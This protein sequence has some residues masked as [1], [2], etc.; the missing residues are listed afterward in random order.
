M[1]RKKQETLVLFPEVMRFT[2]KF[3]DAQ[4]GSLIRSVFSYR[5]EGEVYSGEDM[6]VDV[7]FQTIAGQ[8]DRLLEH[9]EINAKNAS[10]SEKVRENLPAGEKEQPEAESGETEQGEAESSEMQRNHPPILSNPIRS[11]PIQVEEEAAKPPTHQR[12]SPPSVEE[13]RAYCLEKGYSLAPERFVD[14]YA[15]IGW[16]VGKNPMKDWKAALRNWAQKEVPQTAPPEDG[17]C[18]YVLA[19]AEDPWEVAMRERRARDA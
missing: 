2:Q 12:F 16:R 14:Y 19:P 3:S 17:H 7:A 15:S 13:V 11:N 5:F 9:S 10:V 6:A 1:A 4:F 18:G 8:I